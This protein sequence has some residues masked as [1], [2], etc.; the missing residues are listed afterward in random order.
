MHETSPPGTAGSG[1]AAAA[2]RPRRAPDLLITFLRG[3]GMIPVI[4]LHW[5]LD[6]W[7]AP[8][9]PT[10]SLA[11]RSAIPWF[12]W[13]IGAWV[14]PGFFFATGAT[15]W[16]S[17]GKTRTRP[18]LWARLKRVL[19]P[20][21]VLAVVVAGAELLAGFGGLGRCRFF[22]LGQLLSWIV[23]F[24]HYDCL[25]LPSVPLW[26][27]T[28]FVF[29]TLVTPLLYRIMKNRWALAGAAAFA[30]GALVWTGFTLG[31]LLRQLISGL[32][33][34]TDVTASTQ[35][36][37]AF[38]VAHAIAWPAFTMLGFAYGRGTLQRYGRWLV[39]IG[40]V[41]LT[42]GL[43]P[44]ATG[45]VPVDIVGNLQPPSITMLF[46]GGGALLV[47]I[48]VRDWLA[49]A[50][51][52]LHVVGPLDA[53][54]RRSYTVYLWHMTAF[55]AVWWAA[56]EAGLLDKPLVLEHPLG[57]NVV[58]GIVALPLLFLVVRYMFRFEQPGAVGKL[59]KR[60]PK[61]SAA[62]A[63]A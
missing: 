62:D 6:F 24:P 31:P 3:Y 58:I 25:L 56:A 44:M 50:M 63:A 4:I 49:K 26:Y 10:A 28:A 33:G 36:Y 7:T 59:F 45:F 1:D 8:P 34:G 15:S 21:Y 9:D 17:L 12:L 16:R 54:A 30:V 48:G 46:T 41:F 20:Y 43:V 13:V 37:V 52:A 57:R 42:A 27:V 39:L 2:P 5:F 47:W 19:V 61:Q 51:T 18:W 29:V 60:K 14:I 23:P 40:F 53:I 35:Q 22:G 32:N 55:A 38:F 11:A